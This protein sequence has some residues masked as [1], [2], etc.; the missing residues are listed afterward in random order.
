MSVARGFPNAGHFY[1]NIVKPIKIDCNFVVDSTN[2]NGLGLR[3]L[4]SNGFV[5]NV[6]MHTTV[7]PGSNNNYTNPNPAS[8]YALIQMKQNFNS[9]LGG[10]SGF[11]SPVTGSSISI[12]GTSVLTAG[13]PYVII[14]TGATPAPKFTV[15]TV[16]DSSGSLASKYLLV[17]D[18]FGNNYV[19]WFQVSGVGSAPSLTGSLA[20]YVAV[21]VAIATN[22]TANSNATSLSTVIGAL[23]SSGSFTTSVST[24]TVTVTNAST[25]ATILP[26]PAPVDVNTG[27]TVSGFTYTTLAQDWQ[28]MGMPPGLTPAVGMS[29]IATATGG[30]L[31]TGTVKRAGV[32]GIL[33]IEVIGD[34]NTS[35]NSADI[36]SQGGAWILVQFLKAVNT[37]SYNSG[38]PSSSTVST[39]NTP[40][41]PADSSVIG[42]SFFFDGS[43]VSV[44]GL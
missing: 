41:A 17:S 6:F 29:F 2:G 26:K 20:G 43:S 35:I 27:F 42:M 37:F 39:T 21:P 32:S 33:S 28:N 25:V 9:Y 15:A 10:F 14:T 36:A 7:S 4:K 24:N 3:S 30:A 1:S 34:A 5:R 11:V 22:A 44:D 8:G 13:L 38:T 19:L 12:S 16:A 31:G 23:N 18:A 40:A